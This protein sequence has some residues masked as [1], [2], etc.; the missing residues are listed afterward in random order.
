MLPADPTNVERAVSRTLR[1]SLERMQRTA[2]ELDQAV[3]DL[4]AACASNRPANALPS[5]LRAQTASASLAATL[6][7]LSR[8]V[9]SSLQPA[10]REP[11]ESAQY[12]PA[13][14]AVE[15]AEIGEAQELDV[16]ARIEASAPARV[17]APEIPAALTTEA[18][19]VAD[20]PTA[21]EPTEWSEAH[22]SHDAPVQ[23]EPFEAAQPEP[24]IEP[25]ET[26]HVEAHQQ[27]IDESESLAYEPPADAALEPV[28]ESALSP[29]ISARPDAV[30]PLATW[31][32]P[33]QLEEPI[34]AHAATNEI[35]TDEPVADRVLTDDVAADGIVEEPELAP[36]LAQA[37]ADE[38]SK[39]IEEAI[40]GGIAKMSEL[41]VAAL[42][43]IQA[44][45]VA[46]VVT[47]DI[48]LL[49]DDERELHRRASRV[50]KV[51]MQDIK[52]L[53]PQQVAIGRENKD[54]CIRL[55]EEIERAH[56]EYGRRFKP[57]MS[58][59]VDY[60]Y[61]WMVEILAAGDPSA[62]GEYPYQTPALRR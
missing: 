27:A 18:P 37:T 36:E 21:P 26:Q 35:A 22:E 56:K 58:H 42:E 25:A 53:Q 46:A 59:P 17:I 7:V 41:D 9:T 47:F 3:A 34:S 60:F 10:N 43:A 61:D 33:E 13:E 12:A 15:E 23:A 62:L 49:P 28:V 38:E 11:V 8:F 20:W 40:A 4:V 57:I 55:H 50:A 45:P 52:L 48:S 1:D 51:S 19:V 6:D 32:A 30:E 5:M 29:E 16:P 24:E 31:S 54:I 44:E 2:R 39:I 14:A